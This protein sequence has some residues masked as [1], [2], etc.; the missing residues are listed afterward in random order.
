MPNKP[1]YIRFRHFSSDREKQ[2]GIDR[3]KERLRALVR[4]VRRM[5]KRR[6][7]LVAFTLAFLSYALY[8]ATI[9]L[10]HGNNLTQQQPKSRR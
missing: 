5:K 6:L 1:R 7:V 10:N 8:L 3:A 4:E 9:H 2:T